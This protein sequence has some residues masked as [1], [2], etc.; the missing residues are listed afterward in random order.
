MRRSRRSY[1]SR[2]ASDRKYRMCK[3]R[4]DVWGN[5]ALRKLLI[6]SMIDLYLNH[7]MALASLVGSVQPGL[8]E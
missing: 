1:S 4:A 3:I 6:I 5:F 2:L 8:N 7:S